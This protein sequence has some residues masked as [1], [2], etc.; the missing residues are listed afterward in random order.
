M[1]R[2]TSWAGVPAR[3]PASVST[4]LPLTTPTSLAH[5]LSQQSDVFDD[6]LDADLTAVKKSK[7]KRLKKGEKNKNKKDTQDLSIFEL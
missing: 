4:P 1:D 3:D 5:L 2:P 6:E 7:Q